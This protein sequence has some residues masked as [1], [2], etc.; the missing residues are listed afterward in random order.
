ML[1]YWRGLQ[2][3]H[4]WLQG[5]GEGDPALALVHLRSLANTPYEPKEHC[6]NPRAGKTRDYRR[7]G[8]AVRRSQPQRF[9]TQS[10]AYRSTPVP[11]SAGPQEMLQ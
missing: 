5:D 4:E 10:S 11:V 6:R 2:A 9:H 1:D 7:R 3:Y 8:A